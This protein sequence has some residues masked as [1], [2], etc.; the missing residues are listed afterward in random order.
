MVA[1]LVACDSDQVPGRQI[2]GAGTGIR[3][4]GCHLMPFLRPHFSPALVAN[5]LDADAR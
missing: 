2:N 1:L 4:I 5:V 3:R